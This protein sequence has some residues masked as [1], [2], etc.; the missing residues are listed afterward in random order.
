MICVYMCVC[1]C[2]CGLDYMIQAKGF[3]TRNHQSI[4]DILVLK[5]PSSIKSTHSGAPLI[6]HPGRD[7]RSPFEIVTI[8]ESAGA[9][10]DRLVMSHLDRTLQDQ[11]KLLEYAKL[12]SLMEYDLFGMECSHYQVI[13]MHPLITGLI[14]LHFCVSVSYRGIC[15]VLCFN[16]LFWS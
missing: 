4:I 12:G 15:Y 16:W 5:T 3:D 2:V 13:A 10:I 9:N 14:R 11:S 6:I 7:D 1:A 8:L